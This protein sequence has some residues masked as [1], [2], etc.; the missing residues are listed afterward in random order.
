MPQHPFLQPDEDTLAAR[1]KI[2]D[3]VVDYLAEEWPGFTW[4]PMDQYDGIRGSVTVASVRLSHD[5]VVDLSI[6]SYDVE[7][8]AD[9]A[10]HY[11]C[12]HIGLQ[13]ASKQFSIAAK[14]AAEKAK[15]ND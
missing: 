14:L 11:V 1:A 9:L 12:K 7:S 4:E 6:I 10:L 8:A 5:L 13:L 2:I 3:A 15:Q